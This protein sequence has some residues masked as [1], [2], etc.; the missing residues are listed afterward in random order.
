MTNALANLTTTFV[1]GLEGD[2][3]VP[4]CGKWVVT[5]LEDKCEE[6]FKVFFIYGI[7]K[8]DWCW[9]LIDYL[10]HGKLR[11]DVRHEKEIQQRD[12][13]FFYLKEHCISTIF[14]LSSHDIWVRKNENKQ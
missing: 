3:I 13:H 4:V 14:L 8:E 11:S 7:N 5:S 10:K 6:E 1:L 12:S 2:I 9:P